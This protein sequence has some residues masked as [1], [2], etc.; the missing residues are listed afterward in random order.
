MLKS[1]EAKSI[2]YV[3]LI[4]MNFVVVQCN[5]TEMVLD[6]IF[7]PLKLDIQ[8]ILISFKTWSCVCVSAYFSF[9]SPCAYFNMV[10]I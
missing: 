2:G 6:I 5:L 1:S 8:N 10:V 3:S 4:Q 9:V 7:K